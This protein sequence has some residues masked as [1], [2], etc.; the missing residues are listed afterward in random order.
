[1]SKK[2]NGQHETE[3][4]YFQQIKNKYI[5]THNVLRKIVR[6]KWLMGKVHEELIHE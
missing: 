2:T 6:S 5:K 1:M 4:R 3:K